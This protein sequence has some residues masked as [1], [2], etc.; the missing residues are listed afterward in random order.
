VG[1]PWA[2]G[3]VYNY[4]HKD[5]L[6]YFPCK[7]IDASN[8]PFK[9]LIWVD[10]YGLDAALNL[11]GFA[12]GR[13]QAL[14]PDWPRLRAIE[15]HSKIDF[16]LRKWRHHNLKQWEHRLQLLIKDPLHFLRKLFRF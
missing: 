16:G 4:F 1:I 5:I 8:H 11:S 6:S 14:A 3:G 9:D 7:T 13:A 10:I 15:L 12:C 2:A